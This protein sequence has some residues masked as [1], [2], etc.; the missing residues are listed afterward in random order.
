MTD[1]SPIRTIP[2][3]YSHYKPLDSDKRE[4]RLLRILPSASIDEPIVVALVRTKLATCA[5][6]TALSYCWGNLDETEPI[7]LI[8]QDSVE[9]DSTYTVDKIL[10]LNHTLD[11]DD[12][13]LDRSKTSKSPQ[14]YMQHS[15]L[16]EQEMSRA[17][18]GMTCCV[19]TRGMFTNDRTRLAL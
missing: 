13:N 5:P 12:G 2:N 15:I 14:I 9:V 8:F 11:R 17:L 4:L 7:N 18:F 1:P 10:G 3:D 19:S 6:Y 16:S